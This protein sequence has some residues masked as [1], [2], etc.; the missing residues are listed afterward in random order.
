VVRYGFLS[1]VHGDFWALTRALTDLR[2]TERY[3]L[4]DVA[5]GKEVDA[6]IHLLREAKVRSVVGNHDLWDFELLGLCAE[7]LK[8]LKS[9]P[10][11]LEGPAEFL[12]VH[13]LYE[14]ASGKVRF[15]YIHSQTSKPR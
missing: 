10:L 4:G 11:E 7:S 5:G 2:G 3:F 13:S 8:Q 15:P 12:A 1:D 9:W 14:E 6:C